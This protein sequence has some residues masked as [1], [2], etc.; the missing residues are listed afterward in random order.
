MYEYIF[1]YFKYNNV[2]VLV[3]G[4]ESGFTNKL[5]RVSPGYHSVSLYFPSNYYTPD[6]KY[7]LAF[8]TN[9][10]SP[11]LVSFVCLER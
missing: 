3:D 1:V 2:C 5:I 10:D 8:E 4:F 7:I 6:K 11:L 9:E